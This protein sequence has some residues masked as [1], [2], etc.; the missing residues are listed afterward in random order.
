MPKSM[1]YSKGSVIYFEGDKDE[2]IF[3]LQRG[4]VIL[5]SVDVE[6]GKESAESVREGEFFGV[7]SAL[8]HFPREETVRVVTDTQ[9]ISMTVLEFEQL[10]SSNKAVIMK[11][12]RVFSAQ[13]RSIHHK[14]QS[15]LNSVDES[16]DDGILDVASTFF[17]DGNY[18]TTFDLCKRYLTK[19][20]A[21][22]KKMELAKI[23]ADAKRKYEIEANRPGSKTIDTAIETTADASQTMAM[24]Q[25]A[26]PAFSRF[27]K[28][29][30]PGEV[31]IAEHEPG[32]CFYLIQS[33]RVQLVKTFNGTNK[34]IDILGPS[35]FFGEMAILENTP[36]SATCIAIDTVQALEFNKA[37]FELLIT[38]NP[39]VALILLKMFCKRI[40]EQKRRLRILVISDITAR[41]GDVFLMLDETQSQPNIASMS[42]RFNCTIQD[43]AH[44]AGLPLED[45]KDEINR[46]IE[47]HRI[48]IIENNIIV[49]NI[50]EIQR[51]VE[52]RKSI[53]AS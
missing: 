34:H 27:Q 40:Y 17:D 25:F 42:R 49:K 37:N 2:R 46:F 50:G 7:K 24:K 5:T 36:R 53:R 47:K 32:D 15:I 33:G 10:F 28:T 38:G 20:P 41:I 11:M 12:L 44:W 39:Q 22:T 16:I 9:A 14:I 19:F 3:I 1:Q 43:V 30:K 52:Q 51:L 13:L 4:T 6:T 29:Y 35:E 8:G 26:L 31:L 45:T 23:M 18:L 48:E 21:T